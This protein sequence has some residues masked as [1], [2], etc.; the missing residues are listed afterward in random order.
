MTSGKH[1]NRTKTSSYI[2]RLTKNIIC[3]FSDQLHHIQSYAL[4]MNLTLCSPNTQIPAK[5]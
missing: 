2:R 3:N 4:H 1:Y 5:N